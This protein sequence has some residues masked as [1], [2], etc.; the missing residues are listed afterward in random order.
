MANCAW[1][2]AGRPSCVSSPSL[3]AMS[4][5]DASSRCMSSPGSTSAPCGSV[6]MVASNLAVAGIEPVEPAAITGA[7]L[8]A[9]RLASASINM[10]RRSAASMAPSSLRS[11]GQVSRAICRKCSERCQYSSRSSGT[12]VSSLSQLTCRV[13]MSS[14]SRARSSARPSAADG[15][16]AISGAPSAVCIPGEFAHF[17][18][19]SLSSS[20]RSSGAIAGGSA[21]AASASSPVAASAKA[22]SSSSRSPSATMRGS[23]AASPSRSRNTS[24]ARRPARR[25][26]R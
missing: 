12:S 18:I 1:P 23:S 13:V 3:P 20:R 19:S 24:R 21:S 6:A 5:H 15:V 9:R 16:L 25:V 22:I 26:G 10:S 2:A 8:P 11:A 7:S 14:I 4:C 17:R